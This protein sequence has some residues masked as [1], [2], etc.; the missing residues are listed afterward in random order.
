MD[1]LVD[2]LLKAAAFLFVFFALGFCIFVHE[3]GHFLAGRW[4][5]LHID[6][7]SLGFKPFWRK[8][9][10]GVEYR[11][12]YLPFGGY[13][14]LPQ[15]DATSEIPKAADG[16]ELPRAKPL[17]RIITAA[18]GPIF[19]IL[20]GLLLGC[21]VWA[22]GIPKDTPDM[23][24]I[25]VHTVDE[26]G[27]EYAAG[28]RAGDKIV[29]LNGKS[30][31]CTWS[32]FNKELLFAVG[33]VELEVLRGGTPMTIRYTPKANPNAPAG[34]AREGIGWPY[35]V[36]LIPLELTPLPGSPAAQAGL[37]KGDVLLLLNGEAMPDFLTFAEKLPQT[38]ATPVV[39]TVRRGTETLNLTVI[40]APSGPARPMVGVV[41]GGTQ[42]VIGQLIAGLPAEKAGL[43]PKDRFLA[44]NGNKVQTAADFSAAV[45]KLGTTPFELTYE[46]NGE[47]RKITLAAR[48]I[49][50][51][52]IG[53]TLK[54]VG[55][56]NPWQQ[57]VST[58]DMSY[59]SLRGILVGLG[60]KVGV[61]EQT[62]TLKPSHM[63][64]PLGI[65]DVL[66]TSA[67]TSPSYA[68][69]FM[70]ILS[71]ALAIFNLL[72]LPVLD[73]G[74]IVFGLYEMAVGK[75]MPTL[76]IKSLSTVFIVLLIGL[77]VFVTFSDGRRI[78]YRFLPDP[79]PAEAAPKEKQDA[80][81]AAPQQP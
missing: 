21:I 49:T 37:R 79:P 2:W 29:K 44:V 23:R 19:N 8:K 36:P 43:L 38:E 6:A 56:P 48:A 70:V 9:I 76:V 54:L 31:N 34:L 41:W 40:P 75:P 69:Y 30:F 67:R 33:E 20:G 55:H 22:V 50:Q 62:S 5:G 25:T 12:G 27:P 4:R 28:L 16:T 17:D 35:F 42:P 47:T 71:F 46:R 65:G 10:N 81:P 26:R 51:H 68:L 14:E 57:F 7:F 39:L 45:A 58:L 72:P 18:A 59:R 3:L 64:G 15:V 74:H 52:S 66:Y 80:P 13:V 24:E 77:M 61:T 11:L 73:G 32:E 60:N 1:V 53:V 78:V 63:S